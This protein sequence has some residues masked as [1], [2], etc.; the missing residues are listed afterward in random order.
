MTACNPASV[1][2]VRFP[3]TDLSSTKK[4]PAVV[5]SSAQ[6][7]ELH[8]DVVLLPL[9]SVAQAEDAFP[10]AYWREAGLLKPTWA[11]PLIATVS[12]SLVLRVLGTLHQEDQAR[13]RSVLKTVLA[14]PFWPAEG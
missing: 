5:L 8:G 4:R 3:F 11:K 12:E 9:T 6:Y 2:L 13:V 10:L 1:V 7:R 14:Q